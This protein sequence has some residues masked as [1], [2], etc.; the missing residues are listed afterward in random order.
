MKFRSIFCSIILSMLCTIPVN[1][2]LYKSP[3]GKV[4]AEVAPN[5]LTVSY[6]GQG[7]WQTIYTATVDGVQGG[8][9]QKIQVNYDMLTGKQL[10]IYKKGI[11]ANHALKSGGLLMLRVFD[12]G[13]AFKKVSRQ[14]TGFKGEEETK[15]NFSSAINDWVMKWGD[16]AEGFFPQNGE[17]KEGSRW[18]I[19][20]LFEY[21]H[22]VF[23]LIHEA[24]VQHDQAASSLYSTANHNEYRIVT[25]QNDQVAASS[26]W[27]VV[28][29][30]SLADV[31]ESTLVTDV[32]T[33]C[34]IK[35]TSWIQPGVAAWVYWAYNHGSDDYDIIK[36]YT[37]MAV[38]LHLP[39]VL[40][41]AEW[42]RMKNGK[43]VED[44]VRYALDK[45]IKPMIWYNSSVGWVNGAPTPKYRLNKPE[46]REKEFAWCEKIGVVGVKIDFFSGENNMN[47][48]YCIDLLESAAKHHLLV[49]FHG[50]TIPRGWMRTYPNLISTE[51][52]YGAEWYN[53]V[54]SFTPKAASHNATLP[55]TRNV[56]GS[57]DYTPCAFTDSQHPHITTH[58]HELALTA[59][60][61]SGIQHLADRPEGFYAQPQAVKDYIS[62][63]P[64]AWDETRLLSGYPGRDV[65]MAR[66]SGSTWYIS[67]I[68]GTDAERELLLNTKRLNKLGKHI[69]LF[70]D[71]RGEF[72][73]QV[74]DKPGLVPLNQQDKLW[75]IS[76]PQKLPSKINC[77]A[78]GGF[79][80]VVK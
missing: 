69:T 79:V 54:G 25:D 63:L 62:G 33:P 66:R 78:R 6:K 50:A 46:D 1:A 5:G 31:V 19:P 40:I 17:K 34:K 20:A 38:A 45:G 44:A 7:G 48:A 70:E 80:I 27:K 41:D 73:G 4:K 18:S 13:V 24:D 32:S 75:Q 15:I 23:A 26:T 51:G 49:N 74:A 76:S 8:S 28:M 11:E 43:T 21:P 67:G 56:V 72:D 3:N 36:K 2:E 39:Y 47:M 60:Y 77:K 10:H 9:S 64:T 22:N 29:I 65:V 61:E 58:A 59:L 12:D 37:D 55:F 35:D 42:D 52:V 68:N 71:A 57:M 14:S 53:N 16:G 30:G